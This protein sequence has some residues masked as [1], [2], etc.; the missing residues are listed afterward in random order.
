MMWFL[1]QYSYCDLKIKFIIFDKATYTFDVDNNNKD[2]LD[3]SSKYYKIDKIS[4]NSIK[5]IK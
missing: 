2:N 1:S 4:F 5:L 3:L